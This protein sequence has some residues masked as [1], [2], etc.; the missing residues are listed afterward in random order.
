MLKEQAPAVIASWR[1]GS[2]R[3]L[4]NAIIQKK[5]RFRWIPPKPLLVFY[6]KLLATLL[7][8]FLKIWLTLFFK[9]SNA[10]TRLV[11]VVIKFKRLHRHG[12][13]RANLL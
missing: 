10:F 4:G 6:P 13:D 2:G 11:G 9:R 8:K 3:R 7:K 1:D 12:A 5:Q